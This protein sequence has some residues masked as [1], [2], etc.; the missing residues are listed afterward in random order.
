MAD[1]YEKSADN[2][3]QGGGEESDF[4]GGD[5]SSIGGSIDGSVNGGDD[6]FDLAGGARSDSEGEEEDEGSDDDDKS[7]DEAGDVDNEKEAEGFEEHS[8][9][10]SDD[11]EDEEDDD[12]NYLQKMDDHIRA[13]VIENHHPELKTLN[14]EEVEALA[15]IV[16]D[17]EGI[18]VDPL[19][20]TNPIL[21]RYE[22]AR[23]LGER[24][25]Q[26][27][28]GAKPMIEVEPTIIDGYLIALK[29]LEQKRIPF[30][31]Q[32]PLPNGGSEYWRLADLEV[33]H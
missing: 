29:E 31:I 30:I 25:R 6:M 17:K 4:E 26:I 14:Y 15:T 11:D 9:S 10:D 5:D 28:S 12:D 18:I 23:A 8:S 27:N 20:K 22:K 1:L 19:H 32:R 16:R 3:F 33:L 13:K 24:A 2:I 21:S 7:N